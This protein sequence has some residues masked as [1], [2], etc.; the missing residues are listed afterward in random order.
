M[1]L[2]KQI[3][4]D[5]TPSSYDLI[6]MQ[7]HIELCGR[8]CYRSE[9]L[10]TNDS[11]VSFVNGLIKRKH[12][13]V[14]EHGTIYLLID[15]EKNPEEWF[16][17][18]DFYDRN[19]YSKTNVVKDILYVT[20]NYR[21]VKENN[22]EDDL[23][24]MQFN[25]DKNHHKR[26]TAEFFT[27]IQIYKELRTHRPPSFSIESTRFCNYHSEKFGDN[28]IF[29][30]PSWFEHK[31]ETIVAYL[32]DN[33]LQVKSENSTGFSEKE[34]AYMNSLIQIEGFYKNL[35]DLELTPQFAAKV[36]PQATMAHV[37]MTAF[38]DTWQ[39]I[40]NKRYLGATGKPHP[41]M[42]ALMENVHNDFTKKGYIKID[43][44]VI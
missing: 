38:A 14:L 37:A 35:I 25:P 36:L 3:Y 11:Y 26:Y 22:R 40:L 24:F 27:D 7:K 41:D 34:Y 16:T 33:V 18:L 19:P 1:I 15:L 5:I 30:I 43:K 42:V 17:I 10:T 31:E 23:R 44:N 28:I 39:D 2:Q 32:Q 21:V 29:S 4:N 6:S 13:S 8:V 12:F 9:E 20:T